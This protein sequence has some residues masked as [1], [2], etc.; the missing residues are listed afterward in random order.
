ME[1]GILFRIALCIVGAYLLGSIPS[2]VWIGKI[3]YGV[4]VREHGSHNA[5]TTNVMRVLG[6]KAAL[7]VFII[8]V[9]K[10]YLAVQ[11]VHWSGLTEGGEGWIYMK[12]ALCLA[13]VVG[14]I[15]PIFAGFKGGKGVATLVGAAGFGM[16][17]GGIL[18]ALLTFFIIVAWT[19]YV[20]V[21]S[22]AGGL[23]LPFYA[24]LCGDNQPELMVFFGLV[25]LLIFYTHRANIG[26]LLQGTENKTHLFGHR[27]K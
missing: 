4:D 27:K 16:S 15:L 13:A 8:D 9:L 24:A 23:L 21:G 26:R 10:G 12:M 5:G 3:F 7:P 17:I 6:K 25:S 19:K 14:H 18:L 2:A 22:M 20:S 11:L 1:I